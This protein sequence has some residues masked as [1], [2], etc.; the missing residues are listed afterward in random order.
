MLPNCERSRNLRSDGNRGTPSP[1]A[2]TKF[3]WPKPL[4]WS[5]QTT[6]PKRQAAS[7]PTNCTGHPSPSSPHAAPLASCARSARARAWQYQ[8]ISCLFKSFSEHYNTATMRQRIPASLNNVGLSQRSLKEPT[9]HFTS[10]KQ[11]VRR[12]PNQ[13]RLWEILA[14]LNLDPDF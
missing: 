7:Q 8:G 9:P 10:K 12:M 2:L 3:D 6:R 4:L 1:S 14:P 13:N 11:V 5:T